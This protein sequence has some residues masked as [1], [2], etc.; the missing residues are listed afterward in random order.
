MSNFAFQTAIRRSGHR[1]I[2]LGY[3]VIPLRP[4]TKVASLP[5][6][7]WRARRAGH[8]QLDRWLDA[9]PESNL[10]IVCGSSGICVLDAD[11]PAAE[12]RIAGHV[13]PM[14]ARTPRGGRHAYFRPPDGDPLRPRG[15]IGGLPLDLRAGP[16]YVV[17]SPSRSRE[18]DAAWRWEG[19]VLRPDRLPRFEPGW[20]PVEPQSP[21]SPPFAPETSSPHRRLR[22]AEAYLATI[23]GAVSGAGGHDKTLYAAAAL[24]QKFG[25]SVPEAWPLFVRYNARCVPPWDG[26]DLYRKLQEAERL[27]IHSEA[28]TRW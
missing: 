4:G 16:S 26:R 23:E 18:P 19:D 20:L 5:W 3:G 17:A 14:S 21:P 13:T 1:L 15:R 7:D 9:E 22:R 28:T 8:D 27:R 24:V 25:L 10:A 12:R 6:R 2:E 11:S